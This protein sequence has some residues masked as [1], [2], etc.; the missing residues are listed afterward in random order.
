M[1]FVVGFK[2]ALTVNAEAF[3]Q[4]DL[5]LFIYFS[6]SSPQEQPPSCQGA[7]LP[8]RPAQP[9][10]LHPQ[11]RRLQVGGHRR[12]PPT[13]GTGS[14]HVFS[15]T[16]SGLHGSLPS[17]CVLLLTTRLCCA[18]ATRLSLCARLLSPHSVEGGVSLCRP[19]SHSSLTRHSD[20]SAPPADGRL[21]RFSFSPPPPHSSR[22]LPCDLRNQ[23]FPN[24][25]RPAP[26][27]PGEPGH[28]KAP[29]SPNDVR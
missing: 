15:L 11:R 1:T 10:P 2:R 7:S 5:F 12:P 26:Q 6:S 14:P 21:L 23:L 3:T 16:L 20:P 25:P 13:D 18:Q 22:S 9:Q 4:P 28:S 27:G 24:G 17:A 8:Q 29:S 19:V